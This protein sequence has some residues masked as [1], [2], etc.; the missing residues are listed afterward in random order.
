MV[1]TVDSRWLRLARNAVHGMHHAVC[2]LRQHHDHAQLGDAAI[3]RAAQIVAMAAAEQP[4]VI[5]VQRDAVRIGEHEVLRHEAGEVPFGALFS[6]GIGEIEIT[7]AVTATSL[8]TLLQI[9]AQARTIDP[10]G[11]D[12]VTNLRTANLLGVQLRAAVRGTSRGEPEATGNWWPL[13]QADPRFQPLQA[14]IERDRDANLPA[15]ATRRLLALLDDPSGRPA[16]VDHLEG[17]LSAMLRRGDAGSASWLLES[18]DHHAAV[19]ADTAMLLR[20]RLLDSW[21]GAWLDEQL[22]LAT[23]TQLQ[24]LTALGIQL[25]AEALQHLFTRAAALDL[26]LPPGLTDLLG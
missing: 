26:T 22:P 24:A 23:P 10:G 15:L 16:R 21:Y 4:L 1:P 17:L 13:G 7:H 19:P 5:A 12:L 8:R 25:G 3:E 6:A 11:A 18:A 2:V 9:L 20:Q 14:Q